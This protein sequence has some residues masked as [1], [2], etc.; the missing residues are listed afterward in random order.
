MAAM[1]ET[2]TAEDAAAPRVTEPALRGGSGTHRAA[3]MRIET[4]LRHRVLAFRDG[5]RA[6]RVGPWHGHGHDVMKWAADGKP[7]DGPETGR[8]GRRKRA[9]CAES[10]VSRIAHLDRDGA[11]AANAAHFGLRNG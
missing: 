4:P 9:A 1:T 3:D 6:S 7:S 5:D 10:A 8:D 2:S 11:G